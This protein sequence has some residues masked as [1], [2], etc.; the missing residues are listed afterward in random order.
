V[1]KL[2]AEF[3]PDAEF[4]KRRP[5]AFGYWQGVRT[6]TLRDRVTFE[7]AYGKV[8]L[9]VTFAMP[10]EFTVSHGPTPDVPPDRREG[11]YL[12]TTGTKATFTTTCECEAIAQP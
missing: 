8:T 7:A 12:E 4:A 6:A 5:K 1:A 11:F 10:G 3:L 9:R 2:S